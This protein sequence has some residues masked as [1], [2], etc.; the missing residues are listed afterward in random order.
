MFLLCKNRSGVERIRLNCLIGLSV[1]GK[2]AKVF[3]WR[4]YI[5]SGDKKFES[6]LE[7]QPRG[8]DWPYLSSDCYGFQESTAMARPTFLRAW[9]IP[10]V[11]FGAYPTHLHPSILCI[12]VYLLVLVQ[13]VR[14]DHPSMVLSYVP[15]RTTRAL[16]QRISFGLWNIHDPESKGPEE[17]PVSFSSAPIPASQ[18]A[19]HWSRQGHCHTMAN[20]VVWCRV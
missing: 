20:L 3:A 17:V 8:R 15:M 4:R 5:F 14:T 10:L 6:S 2:G 11:L 13:R 12:L 18:T 7:V 9:T 16:C 19:A 1:E